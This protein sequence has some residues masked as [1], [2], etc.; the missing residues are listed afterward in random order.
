M[1]SSNPSGDRSAAQDQGQGVAP[2]LQVLN[3]PVARGITPI[4]TDGVELTI[5][6]TPSL[7]CLEGHF[8]HFPVAPGVV[9]LDWVAHYASLLLHIDWPVLRV[10]RLKFT[11]PIQPNNT[12]V[13]RLIFN[14]DKQWLDFQFFCADRSYS[15]GRVVYESPRD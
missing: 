3:R 6:I 1:S 9:Q 8:E 4:A 11:S 5:D 10:D 7:P 14:R 15:K 12:I 13:I 2:N